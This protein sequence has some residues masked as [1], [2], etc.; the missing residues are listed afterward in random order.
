MV[1]QWANPWLLLGL[2]GI[3]IPILIH[4]WNRRR[5]ETVDWGAMA[6]LEAGQRARRRMRLAEWALLAARMGI[7]ALAALAAARP[8]LSSR[9]NGAADRQAGPAE[10]RDLA[11]VIDGSASMARRASGPSPH[12][13]AVQAARDII[14]GLPRGSTV[15]LL[16]AREGARTVAGIADITAPGRSSSDLIGGIIEALSALDRASH[17][18]REVLVLSDGQRFPWRPDD[19][20]RWALAK[21]L[22]ADYQRRTGASP[23]IRVEL[24][25]PRADQ[26]M[27]DGCV[28]PLSLSHRL[29]PPSRPLDVASTIVNRGDAP[30]LGT[31]DLIIDERVVAGSA[32]AVGPLAPG[33]STSVSFTTTL[34]EPGAHL[35]S[36]RLRTESPDRLPA[37]DEAAAL[38][39]TVSAVPVLVVDGDPGREPLSG[40]AD[41]LR[42][43][44]APEGA[45]APDMIVRVVEHPA[46][47]LTDT[48]G[49]APRVVVL[50]NVGRMSERQTTDLERFVHEGGGLLLA[51]G[52]RS[53]IDW[54]RT[55]MPWLPAVIGPR[56]GDRR[57]RTVVAKPR[58]SSF[59]GPG[60]SRL[61]TGTSPPLGEAGLFVYRSLTPAAD[62][63]VLAALDNGAPWIIEG[64]HGAG[65]ALVMA[66]PL[67]AD[68]GSLPVNPDFVPLMHQLV[69]RLADRDAD[70]AP[71]RAGERLTV[72]L[73]PPPADDVATVPVVGPNGTR[74]PA[75]VVRSGSRAFAQ[76]DGPAEPGAYRVEQAAEITYQVVE[77]DPD[78]FD[79]AP[80]TAADRARIAD[81]W[82]LTFQELTNG[83]ERDPKLS[84]GLAPR[85]LVPTAVW[86]AFLV[87]A[88][89]GLVVELVLTR[90]MAAGRFG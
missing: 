68:G 42:A 37:N 54:L 2:A 83:P 73:E 59:Q 22:H 14:T 60:L 38:C 15:T 50:A 45:Q 77:P 3:V 88:L 55:A 74:V 69:L 85:N 10:P 78:E 90:R 32:V 7:I 24:F 30:Y 76:I 26:A 89:G 8:L 56:H 79:L 16:D 53:E 71:I 35:V 23:L 48:A 13:D 84:A 81:G 28:E 70:R 18:L 44:L 33:A 6:F 61:G 43:A 9:V 52:D 1:W 36:V 39:R 80:L 67:D 21:D 17:P 40:E 41:F 4:L 47:A 64:T 87:L 75:A 65:R 51:P 25:P 58:P 82:P 29:G 20:A 12:Q 34:V 49:E 72:P 63:N 86:R 5:V 57:R 62:A 11:I 19:S 46:W 27:P 66:G 31:A